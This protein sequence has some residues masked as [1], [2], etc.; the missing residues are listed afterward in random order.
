MS[1]YTPTEQEPLPHYVY[2]YFIFLVSF[3]WLI[4]IPMDRSTVPEIE[5]LNFILY[6]NQNPASQTHDGWL[7]F[8]IYRWLMKL[9][10]NISNAQNLALLLRSFLLTLIYWHCIYSSDPRT[11]VIIDGKRTLA[12]LLSHLSIRLRLSSYLSPSTYPKS[13]CF[14]ICLVVRSY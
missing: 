6:E 13:S 12:L 4:F 5:A 10:V 7:T 14:N 9:W 8:F 11:D 2:H 3:V 1:A